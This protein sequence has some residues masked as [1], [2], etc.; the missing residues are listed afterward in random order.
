[1]VE[2]SLTNQADFVRRNPLVF[3]PAPALSNRLVQ[4]LARVPSRQPSCC[5]SRRR[6]IVVLPAGRP[7][8]RCSGF[9]ALSSKRQENGHRVAGVSVNWSRRQASPMGRASEP[10]PK[11]RWRPDACLRPPSFGKPMDR[12]TEKQIAP[13][14]WCGPV[15]SQGRMSRRVRGGSKPFV[16]ERCVQSG[17][18]Q[19]NLWSNRITRKRRIHFSSQSFHAGRTGGRASCTVVYTHGIN[20]PV[21]APWNECGATTSAHP[22]ANAC[23]NSRLD[24]DP[25][26]LPTSL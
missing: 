4:S 26:Q 2:I 22:A 18:L 21:V 20:V 25:R 10:A 12:R 16:P 3:L 9:R 23:R 8:A 19:R 6:A 14:G 24:Q 7:H 11:R 13:S 15:A 5:R 17:L 1:M